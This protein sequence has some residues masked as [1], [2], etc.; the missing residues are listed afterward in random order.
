MAIQ[1]T[2]FIVYTPVIFPFQSLDR[3]Q[4]NERNNTRLQDT[5]IENNQ[6]LFNSY[7]EMAL[8]DT[9]KDWL[10]HIELDYHSEEDSWNS[11]TYTMKRVKYII[12]YRL[13]SY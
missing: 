13:L 10:P 9:E 3:N 11:K 5:K 12:C 2:V 1:Y 6:E 8:T 4:K 7:V